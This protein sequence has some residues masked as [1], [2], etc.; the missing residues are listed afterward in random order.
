MKEG[1]AP[2]YQQGPAPVPHLAV[3]ADLA[4]RD[5]DGHGRDLHIGHLLSVGGPARYRTW[6]ANAKEVFDFPIRAG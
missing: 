3:L 4:S 6:E 5:R 1:P 2:V